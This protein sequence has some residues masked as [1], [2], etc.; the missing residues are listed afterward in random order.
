MSARRLQVVG[1]INKQ[2][3]MIAVRADAP[4][5]TMAELTAAMK[6]KGDKASYAAANPTAKVVGAMYKEQ[7]GLQAVEVSYRTGA[8]YL[9]D[10]ASGAS[11]MQFPTTCWR[12][13]KYVPAACEFWR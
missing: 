5:K 3:V 10:L 2:P 7:A 9:N 13:R 1:T 4:W 6:A 11:I 8:E 12:W